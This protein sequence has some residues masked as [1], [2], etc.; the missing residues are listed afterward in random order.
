MPSRLL[1]H[2]PLRMPSLMRFRLSFNN[3]AG[4]PR[5]IVKSASE[6]AG[7]LNPGPKLKINPNPSPL[8]APPGGPCCE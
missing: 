8:A 4:R 1:G 6:Q 3:M 7:P 5:T 2:F